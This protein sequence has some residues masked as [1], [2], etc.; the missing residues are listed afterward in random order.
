MPHEE[1]QPKFTVALWFQ[2][3]SW[4]SEPELPEPRR[5][6]RET[7]GGRACE[8][9][10]CKPSAG[11]VPCGSL[12]RRLPSAL[13]RQFLSS[14]CFLASALKAPRD[15]QVHPPCFME[16]V[17]VERQQQPSTALYVPTVFSWRLFRILCRNRPLTPGTAPLSLESSSDSPWSILLPVSGDDITSP[18]C[19]LSGQSTPKSF[20]YVSVTWLPAPSPSSL[21]S[22]SHCS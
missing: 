9:S 10:F 6:G 15:C 4:P 20:S 3:H 11:W 2:P 16:L 5:A 12:T 7:Q 8:T 14:P 19:V 21:P 1:A 13:R 18:Y 17:R 22:L